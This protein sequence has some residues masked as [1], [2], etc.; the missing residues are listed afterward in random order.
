M[1]GTE[2]DTSKTKDF[3]ISAV[4]RTMK[5]NKF[6]SGRENEKTAILGMV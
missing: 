6:G 3:I 1:P 4:K 2:L 5:K